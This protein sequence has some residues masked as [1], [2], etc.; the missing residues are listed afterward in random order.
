MKKHYILAGLALLA[1]LP[2]LAQVKIGA[3]GAPDASATLE[4]TGGAG[5]NKGLLLPRLTTVQRNAITSPATGLMIYNTTSN[6][7]QT[8]IGTPAT[9]IW[10]TSP[11]AGWNISGNTGTNPA[12]NFLGTADNQP[13]VVRTNNAE[14]LRVLP[15]GKVGIGTD[16]PLEK[17]QVSSAGDVSIRAKSTTNDKTSFTMGDQLHGIV[18]NLTSYGG[19][20]NDVALFTGSGPLVPASLYLSANP[21]AADNVILNQFALKSTGR[22]GIGIKDPE[23]K[24]HLNEGGLRISSSTPLSTHAIHVINDGGGSANNDNIVISSFGAST[25]PSIALISARGTFAAPANSQPGDNT[26]NLIFTSRING[27]RLL[28]GRRYNP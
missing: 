19:E 13:L 16:S 14:A 5:N 9:P 27:C 4:V 2:G 18:K 22:I 17:L 25:R 12:T 11:T 26:G 3:A 6:E 1:A 15:D 7:V 23:T 24:L 20:A 21:S 28:S 10:S 8:N